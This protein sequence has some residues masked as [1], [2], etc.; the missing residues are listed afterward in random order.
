MTLKDRIVR[1]I[2]KWL[3]IKSPSNIYE[4]TY[5]YN[6]G[7]DGLIEISLDDTF[8]LMPAPMSS[9]MAMDILVSYLLGDDWYVAVSMNGDQCNTVA[10]NE[11]LRKYSKKYRKD[12]AHFCKYAEEKEE[13]K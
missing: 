13:T 12:I 2:K 4:D 6:R 5:K 9:G 8:G 10:V 7:F 11:I 1:R 3:N